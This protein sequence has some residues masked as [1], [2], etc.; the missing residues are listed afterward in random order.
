MPPLAPRENVLPL[1]ATDSPGHLEPRKG[2]G[3]GRGGGGRGGGSIIIINS[4]GGYGPNHNLAIPVWAVVV[5]VFGSII[6][7]LFLVSLHYYCSQERKEKFSKPNHRFRLGLVL[8]KAIKVAL[9]LWVIT[10]LWECCCARLRRGSRRH[11]DSPP[12]TYA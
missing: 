7:F 9:F 11:P 2:G 5:V 6:A 3:G 12:P 4:G 1:L 10:D 8:W